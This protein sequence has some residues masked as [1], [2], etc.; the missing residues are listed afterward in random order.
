MQLLTVTLA[1]L[2]ACAV[3]QP[4]KAHFSVDAIRDQE[5]VTAHLN[6]KSF[7]FT[8]CAAASA[9]L[10]IASLSI[11]P[12]PVQIPGNVTLAL[13]G[14]VLSVSLDSPIAVSLTLE[15]KIGGW[16]KIPCVDDIGSCDYPDVCTLLE[17]IPL[18]NG[19]CPDP[20]PSMGIP[21]RCPLSPFKF[22]VPATDIS[23]PTLPPSVPSWLTNGDYKIQAEG[24][25]SGGGQAFCFELEVS[26]KS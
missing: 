6:L 14:G 15:K 2:L 9:P 13:S 12:D 8:D 4:L 25:T 5:L 16:I 19:K 10:H 18:K 17:K 11:S 23:I 3:A 24:K 20:L 7:S 22:D 26:L 21:C 1:C